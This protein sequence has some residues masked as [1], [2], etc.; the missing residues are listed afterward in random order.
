MGG[1]LAHPPGE[2]HH[3]SPERLSLE[4]FLSVAPLCPQRG[5]HLWRAWSQA[6]FCFLIFV[7]FC[8]FFI[9]FHQKSFTLLKL[10]PLPHEVGDL[11]QSSGPSS[12]FVSCGVPVFMCSMKRGS[13]VHVYVSVHHKE[14]AFLLLLWPGRVCLKNANW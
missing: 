4:C 1:W 13:C 3:W 5:L 11:S 10:L 8:S 9:H 6:M 12:S 14:S 2:M 7:L